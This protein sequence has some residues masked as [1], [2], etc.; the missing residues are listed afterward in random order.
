M[1]FALALL[2]GAVAVLLPA[3]KAP[4]NQGLPSEVTFWVGN[5]PY[6]SDPLAGNEIA[7]GILSG[8][9]HS[10]LVS[11]ARKGVIQGR[12]AE[13][14]TASPD[15]ATWKFHLRENFKFTNG[16]AVT[17]DILRLSWERAYRRLRRED[18]KGDVFS[19]LRPHPQGYQGTDIPG[20]TFEPT[21]VI[22]RFSKPYPTLLNDLSEP[23]YSVVHPSCIARITDDWSCNADAV[24]SGA[25]R[26]VSLSPQKIE[27]ALRPDFPSEF[28]HPRPLEKIVLTSAEEHRDSAPLIFG[29]SA[30]GLE[31]LGLHFH[32]GAVSGVV[33]G[34]CQSWSLRGTPC[35]SKDDRIALRERFYSELARRG[36]SPIRSFFPLA[37]P[38]VAEFAA[39]TAPAH[40]STMMTVSV[41]P[42]AGR[43][44]F[45]N[46]LGDAA[47]SAAEGLGWKHRLVDTSG[48]ERFLEL[49]AGRS[50]Y[51]NDL[52]FFLTEL[53]L[54][55]VEESVRYM[56]QSKE[57]ARLPDIEGRIPSELSKRRL[58]FQRINSVL[59]EDAIV[60]PIAHVGF[61]TWAR[62]DLDLSLANTSLAAVPVPFV[63]WKH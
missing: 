61:G 18:A 27:L 25:Y 30:D 2:G 12:L 62:D 40:A 63:G 23:H 29:L 32:G 22:L 34:R 31:N 60:W 44:R 39:P 19:H 46:A 24:T 17:S 14:W 41:A 52:V 33:F 16:D 59:W 10:G 7:H 58:D 53:T 9:V 55:R 26:I 37:I 45:L 3:C 11:N 8:A 57:G 38:S 47:K 6:T 50:I 5:L 42:I 36:F 15:L 35:H 43:F 21:S 4:H 56:F 13:S 20:V 28:R 49:E 54:D 51:R 48:K 1:R